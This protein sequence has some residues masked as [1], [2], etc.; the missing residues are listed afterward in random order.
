MQIVPSTI[1][2]TSGQPSVSSAI[3]GLSLKLDQLLQARVIETQL[4]LNQLILRIGDKSLPLQTN[5]PLSV[6]PG[7]VL[8]LQVV[9]LVPQLE[10][11]LLTPAGDP[12]IRLTPAISERANLAPANNPVPQPLATAEETAPMPPRIVATVVD[13]TPN[14]LVLLTAP[15]IPR[16]PE[17]QALPDQPASVVPQ[18]NANSSAS[19]EK[20]RLLV[21]NLNQL[22][23][24][25]SADAKPS[26]VPP[27]PAS[28]NPIDAPTP[29][30][31]NTLQSMPLKQ[32]MHLLPPIGA[33]IEL[34]PLPTQAG[35]AFAIVRTEPTPL[36]DGDEFAILQKQLLPI[37]LPLPVL[38]QHL[39]QLTMPNRQLD[40]SVG[41]RLQHLALAIL[42]DLPGKPQL[43]NPASLRNLVDNSGLFLEAK[44]SKMLQ[45]ATN[46]ADLPD[47]PQDMKV[48]L[49]QFAAAL[50]Q[51]IE[52][53]QANRQFQPETLQLL[54]SSLG[55]LH[56]ALAKQALDQLSSLPREDGARQA[57]VVELPFH[58]PPQ[59]DH[60]RLE[61]EQDRGKDSESKP[62]TWAVSITINLPVL[63]TINCKV[64]CYDDSINTRFWSESVETVEKLN[65][66][67]DHLKQQ[68]E[69]K[70]LVAGF[71]EAHP[72]KPAASDNR[73]QP[74]ASLL[75]IKA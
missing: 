71:M 60:I 67:M 30:A 36:D 31:T 25:G 62:N 11:K 49:Y 44:L 20:P 29:A 75:S 2:S 57:W 9:K 73:K 23:L 14:K 70:G 41:E 72:G 3:G 12:N 48:K 7:Q 32:S 19:G 54:E 46:S 15:P 18:P 27:S 64:S 58:N 39:Q 50:V 69:R 1:F 68:F 4:L 45:Q 35:A 53:D 43:T 33:R 8:Q 38:I 66:N 28:N 74:P 26:S 42:R 21:L 61:I 16:Q 65:R 59:I 13:A 55:K 34:L 5:Q 22:W 17:A 51:M 6:A 47:F 10:F 56:G 63:G 37:Q 40:V 52:Q 24:P